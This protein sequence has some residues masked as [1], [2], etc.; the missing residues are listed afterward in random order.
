MRLGLFG[1]RFDPP[2]VG[3]LLLAQ[4]AL[5]TLRLDEVWFVPAKA[6]PHKSAAADAEHRYAL[7]VLAT[8]DH[9]R[10]RVSRVE[11]ERSGT[12]F[13]V[14]TVQQVAERLPDADIHLILGAD[15]ARELADWHR[16]LDLVRACTVVAFPRP[17][18]TLDGLPSELAGHVRQEPGRLVEL[19]G[20]EIRSRVGAGRSVRYLVPRSVEA[21]IRKHSLYQERADT[22][23]A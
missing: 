8:A 17:G 6:P 2:H 15:A 4:Q 14:D 21:Y 23:H 10:F 9:E 16:P 3:H 19:S 5:E 18:E 12:S 11:L 20:T 22:A 13:M 1:G 7:T